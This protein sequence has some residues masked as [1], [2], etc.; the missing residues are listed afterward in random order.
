MTK[1]VTREQKDAII[2][3]LKDFALQNYRHKKLRY[4]YFVETF[5]AKDWEELG[6]A[7]KW[8]VAKIKAEMK[9]WARMW[10]EEELNCGGGEW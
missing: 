6:D 4:D 9:D 2:Q 8:S 1:I 3:G 7:C 10:Y 5:E